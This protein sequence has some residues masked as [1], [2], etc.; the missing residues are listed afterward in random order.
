MQFRPNAAAAADRCAVPGYFN[1]GKV[2]FS[3][4]ELLLFAAI[5][6]ETIGQGIFEIIDRGQK[7]VDHRRWLCFRL[8]R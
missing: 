4:P 6:T 5:R 3:Q 7:L 8:L 1:I 2:L